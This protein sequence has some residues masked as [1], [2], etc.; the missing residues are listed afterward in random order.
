MYN[1]IRFIQ[2]NAFVIIFVLLEIV[3]MVML[4]TSQPYHK[5]V[6]LK[7]TNNIVGGIQSVTSSIGEYFNLK[8]LNE[9]LIAENAEL[10]TQLALYQTNISN[11][12]SNDTIY[13]YI[14]VHVVSN[15]IN[16]AQNYIIIDKGSSDGIDKNMGLISPQGVAGVVCSVSN[17]YSM[18]ISLLHPYTNLSIRFKN[19]QYIANLQWTTNSYRSGNIV[20]IPSHLALNEGDTVVTSG[21]SFIF[22]PDIMVGVVSRVN[23]DNGK[24]LNSATINFA[25]DFAT[26][27]NAYVVRN[28][29]W[30]ELD[31]LSNSLPQ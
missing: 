27:R 23:S 7:T 14:P 6:W 4:L 5:R 17:N 29:N 28:V 22:P 9:E 21:H 1:L 12:Q 16:S 2:K 20:D 3:C 19:N 11:I 31:S 8:N 18:A 24:G 15:K 30:H 25:T 13:E 26:L 10:K